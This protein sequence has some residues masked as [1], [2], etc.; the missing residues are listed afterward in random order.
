MAE[1]IA[2]PTH[3]A[4]SVAPAAAS[5]DAL[6]ARIEAV[7]E[8]RLA[9]RP[10]GE[11]ARQRA[12]RF[13]E[14]LAGHVRP[15]VRSLEAPLLVLLFGP[16][17]AGKSSLFNALARRNVSRVGVLRPT[18]REVVVFVRPADRDA[19]L[20]EG[21][22]LSRL[23]PDRVQVVSDA[24]APEGLALLDAPDL[25]S[26]EHANRELAEQL[27]E[28]ADLGVFVTSAVRY[29]DRVP[30][31]TLAR[32]RE[33]GLPLVV[34]L[35]RM[36]SD[37]TDAAA[38]VR[39][40]RR[41]LSEAG[42]DALADDLT[43]RTATSEVHAGNGH[44]PGAPEVRIVEVAEGE[45][46][47]TLA[48]LRADAVAPLTDVIGR[49]SEDRDHRRALAARALA[50]SLA[51]LAPALDTLADDAEHEAIDVDALGRSARDIFLA[52]LRVLRDD[53]AHGSFLR[54]EAIR[55]WHEFVGADEVTRFFSK[56]IGKVKGTLSA[57]F[58]GMPQAPVSEVRDE[59][60][61][62]LASLT[63]MRLAEA[64]RRTAAAWAGS[65]VVADRIE[66]DPLLWSPAPDLDD[67]IR[68]RLADWATSIADDVRTTGGPKRTLAKGAS[69]GVNAAGIGVM[70]AT[71]SH[72][73][74][75]T[76][77][78]VG[79]AAATGFLNQ[80]LLEALFGEAALVEMIGR[81]RQRLVEQI[82]E[83][84]GEELTR[85]E[86]LITSGDELREIV[87]EAR[88]AAVA[89]R[90]LPAGLPLEVRAVMADPETEDWPAAET[91]LSTPTT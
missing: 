47:P 4:S 14:H 84:F 1:P 21:T 56:G 35:N 74:G 54:A 76:G 45:L 85:F 64:V 55:Q 37:R 89:A 48:A 11:A 78:E 8:R 44:E 67:R 75:L 72:T 29:A 3:H 63:K 79:V 38:I 62:D 7:A 27:V 71:F 43:P 10:T 91:A 16:T 13:A 52:E 58:R 19:V 2:G 80:K 68:G 42:I 18:T 41:L 90:D 32:V 5:L 83:T 15:R 39:D 46:D 33:R 53:L 40:V 50:G 81:A 60:I 26:I 87:T 73:A 9:S 30:W 23:E 36:P 51:G 6:V 17:G 61:E 88:A 34:V 86:G 69:I 31:A 57:L 25:D 12:T 82:S 28:S 66:A 22:A 24:S 59:T 20:G 65:P 70:L 77:A 49:L